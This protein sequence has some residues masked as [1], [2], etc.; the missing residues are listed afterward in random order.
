[1]RD[2][3]VNQRAYDKGIDQLPSVQASTHMW[4]D[5]LIAK[6]WQ[7]TY[8]QTKTTDQLSAENI[9][10]I[11]ENYLNPYSDSLFSRYSEDIRINIPV[12]EDIQLTR[13]DMVALNENV[14]YKETVPTFPI[15][16]SKNRLNYGERLE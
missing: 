16:T 7:M 10:R 8:L 14:P 5:A 15:L 3:I 4:Q 13:I 12:L 11:L 6:Y 1:M 2:Q 9:G